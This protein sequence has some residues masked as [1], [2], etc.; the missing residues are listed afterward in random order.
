MTVDLY[1]T[2]SNKVFVEKRTIFSKV[3]CF[4]SVTFLVDRK[5]WSQE[6]TEHWQEKEVENNPELFDP[7]GIVHVSN[8]RE[9]N[10]YKYHKRIGETPCTP[11]KTCRLRDEFRKAQDAESRKIVRVEKKSQSK[12]KSPLEEELKRQRKFERRHSQDNE[13]NPLEDWK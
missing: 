5:D 10:C 1:G 12:S 4:G 2:G 9:G 7:H 11:L 3:N 13:W 6:L 8:D